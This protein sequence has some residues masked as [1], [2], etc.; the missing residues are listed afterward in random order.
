[1]TFIQ[2]PHLVAKMPDHDVWMAFL[3]DPDGDA[4]ARMYETR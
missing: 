3:A 4:I 1:V 2:K